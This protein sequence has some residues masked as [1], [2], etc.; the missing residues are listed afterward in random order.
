MR[1]FKKLNLI[2]GF[3]AATVGI[4]GVACFIAYGST[5]WDLFGICLLDFASAAVCFNEYAK[6][7][8]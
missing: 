2:M 5:E 8:T 7:D 6:R 4:I 1:K 3:V